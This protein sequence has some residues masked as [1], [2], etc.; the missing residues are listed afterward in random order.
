MN[1]ITKH[2]GLPHPELEL[3]SYE[4]SLKLMPKIPCAGGISKKEPSCIDINELYQNK[5]TAL[6]THFNRKDRNKLSARIEALKDQGFLNQLL[7]VTPMEGTILLH[8][9]KKGVGIS[10]E[11]DQNRNIYAL[12]SVKIGEGVFKTAKLVV[13]ILT[14]KIFVRLTGPKKNTN[15]EEYTYDLNKMGIENTLLS[16]FKDQKE[17]VQLIY[18]YILGCSRKGLLKV[19][20]MAEY[21]NFGNLKSFIKGGVHEDQVI[22]IFHDVLLGLLKMENKEIVHND[23]KPQNI[24]LTKDEDGTVHAKIGDF[25]LAA[26]LNEL[27]ASRF[28]AN[29]THTYLS[30]ESILLE[31]NAK[32]LKIYDDENYKNS[33]ENFKFSDLEK[34][35]PKKDLWALGVTIVKALYGKN[36]YDILYQEQKGRKLINLNDFL[37]LFAEMDQDSL[38]EVYSKD[39]KN[40]KM[41]EFLQFILIIDPKQRPTAKEAYAKYCE[42]FDLD[43][44]NWLLA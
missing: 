20:T 1:E 38:N 5:L 28:T 32:G 15:N 42:I 8:K 43:E 21:C 41:A 6:T 37:E 2:S 9:R 25:G 33:I 27:Q 16:L 12:I 17:F 26:T 10:C 30:P 31:Q 13:E 44:S 19:V 7:N 39:T 18:S 11:I 23:I 24:Y 34:I 40:P 4:E 29:G 36:L 14:G 22:T 35:D 3:K